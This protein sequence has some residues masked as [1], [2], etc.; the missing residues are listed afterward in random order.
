MTYQDDPNP[1]QEPSVWDYFVSGLQSWSKDRSQKIKLETVDKPSKKA[2]F[3][4][5]TVA[6]LIVIYCTDFLAWD[7]SLFRRSSLFDRR[8]FSEGMELTSIKSK[9]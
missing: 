5:L 6:A 7:S 2:S 9:L 8:V 4:W 1:L 3:P